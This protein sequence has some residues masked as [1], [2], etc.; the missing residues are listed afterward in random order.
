MDDEDDP[1]T[2]DH[3][4]GVKCILNASVQIDLRRNRHKNNRI[5]LYTDDS[6]S[7]LLIGAVTDMTAD[8]GFVVT[9]TKS[10]GEVLMQNAVIIAES[11]FAPKT[12]KGATM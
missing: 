9:I 7:F 6:Q 3:L 8:G 2:I 5:E 4:V 12:T 11:L 10:H 1:I